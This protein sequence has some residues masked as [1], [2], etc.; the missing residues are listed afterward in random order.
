MDVA[1]RV[2]LEALP[3]G[4][5]AS[6]LGQAIDA[7]PLQAAMQARPAQMREGGLQSVQAVVP[8]PQCVPPERDDDGLVLGREYGR[9]RLLRSHRGV[10]RGCA[11]APLLDRG[12]A[13]AVAPGQRPHAFLCVTGSRDGLPPS[14]GRLREEPGPWR[15]PRSTVV[16]RTT[17]PRNQTPRQPGSRR[18]ARLHRVDNH[19]CRGRVPNVRKMA[20]RQGRVLAHCGGNRGAIGQAEGDN[21]RCCTYWTSA[22]G[23]IHSRQP[24]CQAARATANVRSRAFLSPY[25][26]NFNAPEKVVSS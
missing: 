13:H 15:V 2:I 12:R 14:C 23:L 18:A 16:N 11:L 19:R 5:V 9:P 3:C 4:L 7:V 6:D 25:S 17:A 22:F 10:G 8:R 20:G 26:P 24:R 21:C 1:D